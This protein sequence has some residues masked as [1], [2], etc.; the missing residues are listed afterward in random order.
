MKESAFLS[1]VPNTA[2][3]CAWA[4]CNAFDSVLH[5]IFVSVAMSSRSLV[6]GAVTGCGGGTFFAV[7]GDKRVPNEGV[8]RN[9]VVPKDGVLPKDV[10]VPKDG[11]VLTL[12]GDAGLERAGVVAVVAKGLNASDID[13]WVGTWPLNSKGMV[14]DGA[15]FRVSTVLRMQKLAGK[16]SI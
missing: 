1:V 11:A 3:R 16:S 4:R 2:G 12:F 14:A 10:V 15:R 8:A 7:H 5:S 6:D 9:D 13:C